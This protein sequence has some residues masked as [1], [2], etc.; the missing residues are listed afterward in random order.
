[1]DSY[2]VLPVP[3]S[4]PQLSQHAR[5]ECVAAFVKT[6]LFQRQQ[7]CA[8]LVS[9]FLCQPSA[10]LFFF[11]F[12]Q[13]VCV[14]ACVHVFFFFFF[15][16]SSRVAVFC[17]ITLSFF[18]FWVPPKIPCVFEQLV[19]EA[20]ELQQATR[21]EDDKA[22][23]EQQ[24]PGVAKARGKRRLPA[25]TAR[26]SAKFQRY[27]ARLQS[28]ME[29]SKDQCEDAAAVLVLLG[30]TRV[31]PSEAYWIP[32]GEPPK[33]SSSP[34]N[35][36][37]SSTMAPT[38]AV[39]TATTV[40]AAAVPG[41]HGAAP[42]APSLPASQ[43]SVTKAQSRVSQPQPTA[44]FRFPLPKRPKTA[45]QERHQPASSSSKASETPEAAA[46]RAVLRRFQL[47]LIAAPPE[48]FHQRRQRH[49]AKRTL[50]GLRHLSSSKGQ[51]D[52]RTE[53]SDGHSSVRALKR[54]GLHVLIGTRKQLGDAVK[55]KK[56]KKKQDTAMSGSRTAL[57]PSSDHHAEAVESIPPRSPEFV[58]CPARLDVAKLFARCK[59]KT[60][61]SW[62]GG[63]DHS[64][65]GCGDIASL[66][67]GLTW[68]TSTSNLKP[69][70]APPPS[71]CSS[72]A[73]VERTTDSSSSSCFL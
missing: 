26:Q 22:R 57:L 40:A 3:V 69:V 16:C 58:P 62:N 6:L 42:S 72:S 14:C 1:M 20:A 64:G 39:T 17:S 65:A 55:K 66:A 27:V 5:A 8:S 38:P 49:P 59:R 2:E 61:L 52:A 32:L 33:P 63:P 45:A 23:T 9:V 53:S 48:A 51:R 30:S 11:S 29:A 54:T 24:T 36:P 71:T 12:S 60:V 10:S 41:S 35:P 15:F 31:T 21:E 73:A 47:S 4:L 13:C 34:V 18:C 43:L 25:R 19:A 67:S 37:T 7:V 46:S 28:V 70:S 44:V 50:S 68:L 56:K